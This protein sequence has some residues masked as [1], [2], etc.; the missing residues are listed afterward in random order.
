M[1]P[2]IMAM[3]PLGFLACAAPA[4]AAFAIKVDL[5]VG[6]ISISTTGGPVVQASPVFVVNDGDPADLN[7]TANAITTII[8]S[9]G[10][11]STVNTAITNT[12]GTAASGGLLDLQYT[13]SSV[14]GGT[15]GTATITASATGF[16]QPPQ[17]ANPLTLMSQIGGTGTGTF[18][19]T[20]AQWADTANGLF[21][22]SGPNSVSHGPFVSSPYSDSKSKSFNRAA[23][24]Y[25]LADQLV[26][27]L[28]AN[29]LVTGDFQS[30]VTGAPAP[31]GLFLALAGLPVLGF[32]YLRRR[33]KK[34]HNAA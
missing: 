7:P 33:L 8:T 3:V 10:F 17:G 21:T 11:T 16:T 31:A 30:T 9:A 6:P 26:V 34:Q 25:S 13:I 24:P 5:G 20:A 15:G 14:G 28:G 2:I 12:P 29:S 4:Q 32:G 19:L 22:T 1:W 18:N 23:T 27:T